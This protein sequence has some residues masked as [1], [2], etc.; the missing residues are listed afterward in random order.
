MID[1]VL[2]HAS[3][4]SK[5]FDNFL[6]GSGKGSDYFKVVKGWDGV[7]QIER[8]R[9]S[10]LF[11][12]IKTKDGEKKVWCTFSHDQID[13]DFSNPKVLLEFLKIIK[14]Y[15]LKSYINPHPF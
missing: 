13:L 12:L 3:K 15:I 1:I 5:W 14:F 10:K 7:A 9:S 8:P 6:K 4:E 2:N 11:Q